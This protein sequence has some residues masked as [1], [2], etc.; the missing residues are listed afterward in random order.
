M[1]IWDFIAQSGQDLLRH[2]ADRLQFRL[3][4]EPVPVEWREILRNNVPLAHS[5]GSSDQDL[6]LRV[7]RLLIKEVPFEGCAGLTLTD[8]IR[9]TIATT[10]ALLVFRLP[11]PRFTKLVRVLVYPDTFVPKRVA[12][13]HDPMV[14]EEDPALGQAAALLPPGCYFSTMITLLRP[15]L[16][17]ALTL[18]VAQAG[19]AQARVVSA[20]P[21]PSLLNIT[22]QWSR[23]SILGD[24]REMPAA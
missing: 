7:A 24:L 8:E 2:A 4:S 5:L 1:S 15:A 19:F 14:L 9:V 22:R 13:T 21:E 6:L 20:P 10:A 11:Y 18:L 17:F 12:S 16:I 23:A 3:P